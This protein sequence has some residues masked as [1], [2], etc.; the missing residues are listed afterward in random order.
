MPILPLLQLPVGVAEA[1]TVNAVGIHADKLNEAR[2]PFPQ[3]SISLLIPRQISY[4]AAG[5][6]ADVIK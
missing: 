4:T 1:V 3:A 5:V 6:A 2:K